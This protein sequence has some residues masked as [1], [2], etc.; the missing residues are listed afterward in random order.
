MAVKHLFSRPNSLQTMLLIEVSFNRKA[1][2]RNLGYSLASFS[3]DVFQTCVHD[4]DH[5]VWAREV[6]TIPGV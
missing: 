6:C 3:K 4:T 5:T 2:G 1:F